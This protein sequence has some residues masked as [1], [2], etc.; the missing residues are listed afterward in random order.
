MAQLKPPFI[1]ISPLGASSPPRFLSFLCFLPCSFNFP[2][3][4]SLSISPSWF[5][6]HFLCLFP[7]PHQPP[8]TP[9][10]SLPP[11]PSRSL[12]PWHFLSRISLSLTS[13]SLSFSLYLV[14][15]FGKLIGVGCCSFDAGKIRQS[16]RN[17]VYN[18]NFGEVVSGLIVRNLILWFM[19]RLI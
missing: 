19:G 9:P 17:Y 7:S 12:F 13:V 2:L 18:V 5:V 14:S 1:F 4:F 3:P 11:P 15:S 6:S 16:L 10:L 8:F